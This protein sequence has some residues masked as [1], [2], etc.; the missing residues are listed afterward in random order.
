MT[1]SKEEIGRELRKFI[2]SDPQ[3]CRMLIPY[4]FQKG[5]ITRE[6]A[7]IAFKDLNDYYEKT[8]KTDTTKMRKLSALLP[9]LGFSKLKVLYN[10][11]E[12][13]PS[14][15]YK[16]FELFPDDKKIMGTFTKI[17]PIEYYGIITNLVKLG[18]IAK[19][20][21]EGKKTY[22]I[23]FKKIDETVSLKQEKTIAAV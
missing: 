23:N 10:L 9:V 4:A 13:L 17:K 18:Y 21:Q 3:Y 20:K 15:V 11:I 14:R 1:N 2:D 5:T 8:Q 22:I 7:E 12:Q 16:D 6:E 19:G